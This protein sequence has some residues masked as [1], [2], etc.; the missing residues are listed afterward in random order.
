MAIGT[1]EQRIAKAI[2]I[3]SLDRKEHHG[4]TMH[5]WGYGLKQTEMRELVGQIRKEILS[6]PPSP[7]R[8]RAMNA[9]LAKQ[10]A[11]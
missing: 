9:Q 11:E 7:A 5:R 1:V 3:E 8:L 10:A 2:A 4:M 6:P